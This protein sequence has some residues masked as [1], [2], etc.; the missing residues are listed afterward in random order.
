MPHSINERV[1][2]A[3]IRL[4]ST[5]DMAWYKIAQEI[6]IPA[7]TLWDIAHGKPVP[8]K[9]K[10]RWTVSHDL[11]AMPVAELRWALENREEI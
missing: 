4:H 7:G 10:N 8:R 5:Y 11:F 2:L 3:V 1:R 6:G 9:W